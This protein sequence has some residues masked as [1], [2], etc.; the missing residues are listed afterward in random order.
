MFSITERNGKMKYMKAGYARE[1]LKMSEGGYNK[2]AE[3][4]SR[5]R[6]VFWEELKHLTKYVKQGDRVLDLGCGNGRFY[7]ELKTLKISYTGIDHSGGLIEQAQKKFGEEAIFMYG[8]A[9]SLPFKKNSYDVVYSFAVLHHIPSKQFRKLFFEEIDRVL[10]DDGIAIITVWNI[11]Q[12][13]FIPKI[14][15]TGLLKL[16]GLTKLDFKDFFLGFGD[17][18]KVRYLHA[19]TEKELIK[20]ATKSGF[21][22]EKIELIKRRSGQSNF[23]LVVRKT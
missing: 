8:D 16:I 7:E 13:K 19:F 1:I 15:R 4:F 9:L 11:W 6:G 3:D 5:T 21:K 22:V 10:K 23:V 12:K 17:N 20:L 2:I 18:K 14:I